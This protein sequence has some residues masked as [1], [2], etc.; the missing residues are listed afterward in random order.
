MKTNITLFICLF[1][2]QTLMAQQPWAP[3]GTTWYYTSGYTPLPPTVFS[4]EVIA[5]DTIQGIPCSV[6]D[7]GS[8]DE[9]VYQEGEKTYVF[10]AHMNQFYPIYDFS[11]EAG[12]TMR[13]YYNYPGVDALDSL[14]FK[15]DIAGTD[16][17]GGKE[18]LVQHISMIR[19]ESYGFEYSQLLYKGV[20]DSQSMF[21]SSAFASP[22]PT[23]RCKI[24]PNDDENSYHFTDEDCGLISSTEELSLLASIKVYPNPTSAATFRLDIPEG[25]SIDRITLTDLSGKIIWQ[26]AGLSYYD[27]DFALPASAGIYFVSIQSE[28]AIILKKVI[29]L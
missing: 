5:I 8:V 1:F 7:R 9:Y 25:S 2:L 15:V 18:I 27:K 21:P 11:L 17:I 29:K 16:M 4:D 23:I 6:F 3:V 28:E 22:P 14:T 13:V 12:D 19:E 10:N 26:Q 20:G 24:V